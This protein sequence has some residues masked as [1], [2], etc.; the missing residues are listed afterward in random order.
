MLSNPDAKM[1]S[2]STSHLSPSS[3]SRCESTSSP[4]QGISV[5]P[6]E[7]RCN[8]DRFPWAA[9]K[10]P[11]FGG[12]K[13]RDVAQLS[14]S[15]GHLPEVLPCQEVPFPGSSLPSKD[16]SCQILVSYEQR[17]CWLIKWPLSSHFELKAVSKFERQMLEMLLRWVIKCHSPH[18][19]AL[20]VKYW[21]VNSGLVV[22]QKVFIY[23]KQKYGG[24]WVKYDYAPK[25]PD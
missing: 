2:F 9:A 4:R 6:R 22:A 21:P 3:S 23:L 24:K 5:S 25:S 8:P 13:I 10:R 7:W 20:G 1:K 16:C 14:S 18:L 19:L 17:W 12:I 11:E 15:T